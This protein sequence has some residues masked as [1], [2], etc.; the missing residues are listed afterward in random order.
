MQVADVLADRFRQRLEERNHIMLHDFLDRR[1]PTRINPRFAPDPAGDAARDFA[2]P[3]QRLT[4]LQLDLQPD[5]ILMFKIPDLLHSGQG[6][7]IN[8]LFLRI[9]AMGYWLSAMGNKTE[10]MF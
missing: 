4:G 8:H 1:N 2:R 9:V 6:V 10:S 7:A 3:L 5:L